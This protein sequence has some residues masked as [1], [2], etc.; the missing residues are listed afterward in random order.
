MCAIEDIEHLISVTSSTLQNCTMAVY[1]LDDFDTKEIENFCYS[2]GAKRCKVFNVS[3]VVRSEGMYNE[4]C[5][6]KKVK[7]VSDG[8]YTDH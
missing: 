1:N 7:C 5:T 2:S 4:T 6:H 3:S 8:Y